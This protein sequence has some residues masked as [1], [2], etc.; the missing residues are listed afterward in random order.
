M[1]QATRLFLAGLL[2]LVAGSFS[3]AFGI[4][5]G[6][7]STPAIRLI[8]MESPAIALGTPLPLCIPSAAVGGLNYWRKG[9]VD[10][11]AVAFAAP[12]GAAMS[13]G[14][15]MLTS[16]LDLHFLMA[17]T[18]TCLLYL[19][20]RT[21]LRAWSAPGVEKGGSAS[22]Q[23]WKLSLVGGAAGFISGLLGIGGGLV[24][25]PGFL[26]WARMDAKKALGTSLVCIAVLSVPGTVVHACLGHVDWPL[27]FAMA[28]GVMP[29]SWLGSRFT[30]RAKSRLVLT[31]FAL[32]LA[33]T[34]IIFLA[35]ELRYLI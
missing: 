34:G 25:V 11:R 29:G 5:G 2:G 27:F 19:A 20:V 23:G 14:G 13:V 9:K 1:I 28:A 33:A 31:L 22:L 3:G 24:M 15:A 12:A 10:E 4:G 35:S 18:A 21:V 6:I 32:L 26:L 16:I 30:L 17:L 8:L 7:F